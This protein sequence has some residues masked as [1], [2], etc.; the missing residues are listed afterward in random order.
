MN[1]YWIDLF[2]GAGGTSTGIHMAN[3]NAKVIACVNHDAVAIESHRANHPDCLHFTEDIRDFNVVLKLKKI[4]EDLRTSDPDCVINIWASLE[5]TNYSKAKGGMPRDADSRTLAL[6]MFMYIDHLDPEYLFIENV[7]EFMAWGPLDK[8]GK[9]LS[10]DNGKDYIKW[11]QNIEKRG[12][13][14]S[15][16]LLN[17]ANFGAYTSRERYFGQF[18]KRGMPISWPVATHAKKPDSRQGLFEKPKRKWKAVKEV[19]DLNDEGESIFT[20]KKALSENT[21]K[22]IY[23]GLIKFIAN[24]ETEFI[25]KYYSGRPAGKVISLNGPAGTITTIDGQAVVKTVLC[26]YFGNSKTPQSVDEPCNTLTTKDR[27]AKVDYQFLV[28]NYSNGGHHTDL[29]KPAPTI[30]S[31]PKSNLATCQFMDQQYGNSEP[32][33]IDE[34]ANTL[35]ANPK[36]NLVTAKPWLMDTSFNN[37][38]S[39]IDEPSRVILAARKH[40]Y[41]MNPKTWIMNGNSSTAPPVSLERPCPTVTSARTHYLLNPQYDSK[42]RSIDDPCFT[43][44]ARMDKMPPYLVEVEAGE[45]AIV[46]FE[47]DSEMTVKIKEFMAAYGIIDIKMR[48]LKILELL[49]IQGFP[50]GYKLK[51]TKT[52]QKK[53]IGNSVNPQTAKE[54]VEANYQSIVELLK[55]EA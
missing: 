1:V 47:A 42:G 38:G 6:D 46:I 24:G 8:N 45:F 23:A 39:S 20:R 14:Y 40:H 49:K 41:L 11:I 32:H 22:R 50:A 54:I 51:G 27:F 37:T 19:L 21:L 31:I 10:R 9:P 2:C 36:F 35:T 3:V 18:A 30:T 15:Y 33:S 12:Y 26:P 7:R 28:N 55:T 52:E 16:R 17:S 13:D 25:Q 43:L 29:K 48:M 5:C 53:F 44:I 4:V 34:S